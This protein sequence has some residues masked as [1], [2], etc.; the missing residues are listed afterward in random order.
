MYRLVAMVVAFGMA[1][2]L[3]AA[4][5]EADC[6]RPITTCYKECFYDS[7]GN[8]AHCVPHCHSVV[9]CDRVPDGLAIGQLPQSR[10]AKGDLPAGSL[11]SGHLPDSRLPD[12]FSD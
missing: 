7:Y 11:P 2:S 1:W 10:L 8:T 9:P 4:A 6:Q 5:Q 3:G 12:G